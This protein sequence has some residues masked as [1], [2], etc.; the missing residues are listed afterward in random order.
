[1]EDPEGPMFAAQESGNRPAS[2]PPRILRFGV[3]ELDAQ[4]GELRRHGLRI[5]LPH[6]AFQILQ[7]LL[8]RPGEIVSREVIR[9]RLWKAGTHVEFDVSLNTAVRKLREALDDSV[10]HPQFIETLPRRGYRF[11]GSVQPVADRTSVAPAAGVAPAASRARTMVVG[12]GLVLAAVIA[13]LAISYQRGWLLRVGTAADEIQSLAVLPF[14]NLTGDPA[15][16]YLADGITDALTTHLAQIEP[17]NVISHTSALQYKPPTK[18][19][20]D[21]GKELNVDALVQGAVVRSGHHLRISARLVRA[22]TDRHVWAQSYTGELG[23]IVALQQ[24][25]GGDV[26]AAI[27]RR[28]TPAHTRRPQT[29]DPEAADAYLKGLHAAG[30]VTYEGFRTAVAYFEEA[31]AKQPDYAEAYAALGHTQLRFLFTGPLSPRETVPKAEA[32]A[33]TALKLDETLARPH[34]TLGQILTH[35]Y[36]K[37]DEGEKEFRRAHELSPHLGKSIQTESIDPV[38]TGRVDQAIASA[39]RERRREPQSFDAHV[40]LAVAYRAASQRDRAVAELHRALEIIPGRARGYFQLGVTFVAMAQYDKAVRELEAA[41]RASRGAT[42]RFS[43]YLGYAYA[44]AG[45]PFDARRILNELES[46]ARHQYVSSFG[47]ALIHDALGE[48]EPALAALERAYEDR[49]VEFAQMTR[50]PAFKTIASDPRY[51]AMM[52]R[53]GLP[54]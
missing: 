48:K 29:V 39:E 23:D 24:R 40:N 46:R 34:M 5:R 47:I 21:I 49:A 43:A 7:L 28:L 30:Q 38:R 52:Q 17:V 42:P 51:E 41:V 9:E 45:R 25:I 37:W 3:F 32:A 14:E 33:R 18:R 50:Y 53:I 2:V 13:A 19:L 6:Q 16:E 12:G 27:G 10:E 20:P 44:A 26:A 35:F 54:R 11:I 1:M 36:W 31:V 4:S 22:A 15:Q 8:S